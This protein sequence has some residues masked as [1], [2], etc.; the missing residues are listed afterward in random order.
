MVIA[1]TDR[2]M[3]MITGYVIADSSDAWGIVCDGLSHRVI[4]R[5]A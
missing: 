2:Q 3:P 1:F 4:C 5:H